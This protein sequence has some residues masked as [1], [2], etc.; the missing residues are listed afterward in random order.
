MS[1]S[2]RRSASGR[3]LKRLFQAVM[4]LAVA[5]A[6]AFAYLMYPVWRSYPAADFPP[7]AT[8]ADKNRQD[9]EYLSRLPEIDR[10]F[11]KEKRRAFAR[12][13]ERLI[14]Q[15][16]TFDRAKLTL[17]AARLTALA[18]NG[19]T[20]VLTQ[21]GDRSFKSVPIRLGVFSD[22]LFVVKALGDAQDLVGAQ[23]LAVNDR[24][25]DSVITTFRPFI[26]GPPTLLRQHVPRLIV[27]P[28][29]LTAAGL[30]GSA[31]NS[32]YRFRLANGLVIDRFLSV[33]D[34]TPELEDN[35][36]WPVR[37]LSPVPTLT[38]GPG[39]SHVL[40]AAPLYLSKLDENYWHAYVDEGRV[41]FLQINRMR[42]Q[43]RQRLADHLAE[44]LDT[45]KRRG[46]KFVVVDLRY[47]RGGDYTQAADFARRLADA[48]PP[49]GRIF[50][51][52]GGNSFSAAISTVARIKFF[53]GGRATQVGEP[54]GDRGQFWGEGD[55][56]IL[57]HSKIAVRYAT[58]YHDWENGCELEQITTCFLLNYVYGA[59]PGSL[60]PQLTASP[61]FAYYASG[62]DMVMDE[63]MKVI[64]S[65]AVASVAAGKG[66]APPSNQPN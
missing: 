61:R 34:V 36:Y 58:A 22:G 52:T 48:V 3:F 40:D 39:W 5:A 18:D 24:P 16:G 6:A 21:L 65:A 13:V 27:S 57:P 17:E 46:T 14:A 45:I 30:N 38:D 47:N 8:E 49:D 64:R 43:G 9:L 26:G 11:T 54:M 10:S 12:A 62:R 29:L 4:V 37:D 50:I 2:Q 23:L 53:A 55:R 63:V 33:A 35:P 59:A 25:I 28:E 19:H 44:V 20:N 66:A 56:A 51:L 41:L 32:Q 1:E 60:T 31:D 42:D 15:S 7:A